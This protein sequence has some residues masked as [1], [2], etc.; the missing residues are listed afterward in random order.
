MKK[1]EK[2]MDKNKVA[3]DLKEIKYYYTHKEFFESSYNITG[4][5]KV[6][7]LVEKYNEAICNADPQ[8]HELYVL[9][10]IQG[11]SWE[12]VSA[13]KPCSMDYVFRHHRRLIEFFQKSIA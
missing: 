3:N 9:M 6:H 5:N 7:K 11:N 1:K 2:I 12:V 10:Y 13:I 8:L 4:V